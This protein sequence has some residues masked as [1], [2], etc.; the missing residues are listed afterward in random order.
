VPERAS[1]WLEG[2]VGVALELAAWGVATGAL[3]MIV[4]VPGAPPLPWHSPR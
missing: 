4:G 1:I 2:I 3:E